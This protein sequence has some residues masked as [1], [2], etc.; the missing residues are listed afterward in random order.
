MA[1]RSLELDVNYVRSIIPHPSI[2]ILTTV[3][4]SQRNTGKS[5]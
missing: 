5:V 1:A 4:F 2:K 3:D